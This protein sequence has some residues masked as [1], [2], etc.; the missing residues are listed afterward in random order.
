MNITSTPSFQVSCPCGEVEKKDFAMC[1]PGAVVGAYY[2]GVAGCFYGAVKSVWSGTAFGT[3]KMASGVKA[4]YAGNPQHIAGRTIT[5]CV[6]NSIYTGGKWAKIGI[7]EGALAFGTI[8]FCSKH[9][10]SITGQSIPDIK[11]EISLIPK[12]QFIERT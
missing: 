4:L 2:F 9:Y 7:Q 12:V 1:I 3:V 5:P 6:A 11:M 10:Q 8:G